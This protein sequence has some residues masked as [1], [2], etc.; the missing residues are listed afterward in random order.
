MPS[1]PGIG[2]P[3]GVDRLLDRGHQQLF[4]QLGDPAVS[5]VDDLGEV[6][7]GVHVHDGEGEASR[8]EMPS[9]PAGG[10]RP[11]PCPPLNN[12]TGRSHSAATSRM[13]NTEWA[14]RRSRWSTPGAV[15]TVEERAT[16][17]RIVVTA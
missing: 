16:G 12:S 5:E 8:A 9:R 3:A 13:M 11:S 15:A 6:V 10:G 2:H 14:S 17:S 4:A 1:G 7:P